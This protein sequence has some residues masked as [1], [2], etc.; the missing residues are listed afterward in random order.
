MINLS[1]LNQY[2]PLGNG[3]K[4]NIKQW[5][6]T[7]DW[8]PEV[9]GGGL[10][11]DDKDEASDLP[12]GPAS[13]ETSNLVVYEPSTEKVNYFPS[14]MLLKIGY[15][16]NGFEAGYDI[17]SIKDLN[18][19]ELSDEIVVGEYFKNQYQVIRLKPTI[20]SKNIKQRKAPC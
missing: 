16:Y 18:G 9:V 20:A 8:V 11:M 6:V 10:I 17:A 12:I 13:G 14:T 19:A 15:T 5:E 4:G 2:G 3:V 7:C 1:F